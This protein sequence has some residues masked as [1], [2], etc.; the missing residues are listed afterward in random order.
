VETAR[1]EPKGG[2]HRPVTKKELLKTAEKIERSI[3]ALVQRHREEEDEK[4]IRTHHRDAE[5]RI[6]AT[7]NRK[8]EKLISWLSE[9]GGRSP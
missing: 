7:L 4:Q 1:T 3:E 2:T 5:E 8:K 9:G 6:I